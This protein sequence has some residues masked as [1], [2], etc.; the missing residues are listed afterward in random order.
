MMGEEERLEIMNHHIHHDGQQHHS[1][2]GKM[3]LENWEE[4]VL[5]HQEASMGVVDIKQES[6]INNNNGHHLIC[7]PNSPPNKSC[8]T[9]TTTT[10]TSLNS[11]DDDNN[12]NNNIMFDFSSNHNGL[13]FSEGR[14]TPPDQSSEVILFLDLII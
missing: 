11:T 9:T 2:Q 8:V 10:T 1:F 7:S 3:R 5:S 4:Q 6:I 13:N 12:N 14:H